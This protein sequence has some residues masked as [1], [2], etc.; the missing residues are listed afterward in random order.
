MTRVTTSRRKAHRQCMPRRQYCSA[1]RRG[2]LRRS[3]LVCPLSS[4]RTLSYAVFLDTDHTISRSAAFRACFGKLD[5]LL[6]RCLSA[7]MTMAT[8]PLG[9]EWQTQDQ[10]QALVTVH[11]IA[12]AHVTLH[13]PF[14]STY[15]P[16]RRRC[17]EGALSVVRVLD[18]LGEVWGTVG[19]ISP[20]YAV[21]FTF[22]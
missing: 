9:R 17:V 8:V 11:L 15:G 5:A 14:I 16:S 1:R 4:H 18:Q 21:C 20:I 19:R 13:R 3:W 12:L 6:Q 22:I 2:S 10:A 7:A